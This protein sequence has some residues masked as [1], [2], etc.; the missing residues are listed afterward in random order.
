DEDARLHGTEERQR[1]AV[2]TRMLERVVDVVVELVRRGRARDVAQEPQL[3]VVTHMSEVPDQ[4]RH[5]WRDLAGEVGVVDRR[6]ERER[7]R[8]CAVE[9]GLDAGLGADGHA[10]VAA[11]NWSG[12]GMSAPSSCQA[13][14]RSSA[15]DRRRATYRSTNASTARTVVA[16]V[17]SCT[18]AC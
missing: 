7:A 12:W 3:F 15:G 4:R 14:S 10:H 8:P 17:P 6:Q 11:A 9:A 2:A 16:S 5:E 1:R 18:I 13:S